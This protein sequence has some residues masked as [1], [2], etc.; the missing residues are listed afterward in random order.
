[1]STIHFGMFKCIAIALIVVPVLPCRHSVIWLINLKIAV[2]HI[3][4]DYADLALRFAVYSAA[5]PRGDLFSYTVWSSQP[6]RSANLR[7]V[8]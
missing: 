2:A 5:T 8:H 4:L 7:F 1:M 3:D 6:L